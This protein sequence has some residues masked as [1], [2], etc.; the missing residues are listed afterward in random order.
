MNAPTPAPS[1]SSPAARAPVGPGPVPT[2]HGELSI[3]SVWCFFAATFA[4]TWG[5]GIVVMAFMDEIEAALGPIGYTNPV[6]VLMVY[7]PGF[8][9]L[10]MVWRHHGARGLVAF[11]RRLT[12]WRM[13][14]GWWLLLVVGMPAVFY[15]GAA[16]NGNLTEFPFDP[17]YGDRRR[18]LVGRSAGRGGD[19]LGRQRAGRDLGLGRRVYGEGAGRSEVVD[20]FGRRRGI[21]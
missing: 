19:D 4:V 20:L 10:A 15:V 12:L 1:T 11:L 14:L 6:F 21:V 17:W 18:H 9:A 13:S 2:R 3:R 8:V 16:V 5:L 7:S